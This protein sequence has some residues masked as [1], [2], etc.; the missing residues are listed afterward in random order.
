M[1]SFVG[2][3]FYTAGTCSPPV[4][5][6][7]GDGLVAFCANR[8]STSFPAKPTDWR[9]VSSVS[10]ASTGLAIIVY[11]KR[12]AGDSSD[13]FA[14]P[15]NCTHVTIGAWSGLRASVAGVAVINT[16]TGAGDTEITYSAIPAFKTRLPWVVEYSFNKNDSVDPAAAPSGMTRRA[17]NSTS[18][19]TGCAVFDDTN[20]AV[21]GFAAKTS[22]LTDAADWLSVALELIP[23]GSDDIPTTSLAS[24]DGALLVL[25]KEA[26]SRVTQQAVTVVYGPPAS[27]LVHASQDAVLAPASRGKYVVPRVSQLFVA[28]VYT[29]GI[30]DE[31]RNRCWT[32]VFDGHT[33]YV[34]DLGA[35]GTWLYDIDT[36]QWCRF[37]T[38]GYGRTWNMKAG[39]MW[40]DNRVVAGDV[41]NGYVWE[42]V[43]TQPLDEGWRAI[44]HAVTG[45]IPTRSRV[46]L[47]MD[48]VRITASIGIL[49][50]AERA[51]FILRF[52]DDNGQTW[53]DEYP[54]ALVKDE[55]DGEL[56]WR[57]LGSFMAPGRVL[58]FV[59]LGGL[60]RIDG[61]DAFIQNFD[62]GKDGSQ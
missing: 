60:I 32:F 30:P 36:K 18:S 20:A 24:V 38:D 51:E 12:A 33:F 42:L 22:A 11:V 61:C 55:F 39:T 31:R 28:V 27:K 9:E 41:Q 26:N 43:P 10:D 19:P 40:H 4:G 62:G 15:A 59:D 14:M 25:G 23:A 35:E 53:S 3:A 45:G 56:A 16:S 50:D 54:V 34:L 57:S 52:S 8:L 44:P 2:S 13:D 48:A 47:P 21:S 49:G 1:V 46:Y 58:E 6:A 29:T 7:A 5:T 17:G 37:Y